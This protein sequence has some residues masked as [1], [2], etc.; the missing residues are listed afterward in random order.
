MSEAMSDEGS[1]PKTNSDFLISIS[2]PPSTETKRRFRTPRLRLPAG[3]GT[4]GIPAAAPPAPSR[5]GHD[6]H[7]RR[8]RRGVG[9]ESTFDDLARR[10]AGALRQ[11]GDEVRVF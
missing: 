11:S 4:T 1:R 7:P 3:A 10:E 6:G 2:G 5:S 9:S 8:H